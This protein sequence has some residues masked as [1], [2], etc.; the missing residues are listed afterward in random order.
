MT[1]TSGQ[2]P[3]TGQ[4]APPD[5]PVPEPSRWVRLATAN[6][7]WIFLILVGLVIVFTAFEPNFIKP[8]NIRSIFADQ[9]YL[10]V[11][12]IGET[13]V[14]VTA[15]IDLSVGGVLIFS[16]VIAGK[17]MLGLY[18]QHSGVIGAANA[19]WTV[20]II[21]I[22]AGIVAGVAWGLINGLLVAWAKV[23]PL[24]VTLG[25]LGM[26]TGASYLLTGGTDL[27][28]IPTR[29]TNLIGFGTIGGQLP[30][31]VVIAGV[32]AVLCGLLLAYTRFGRYTYAVGSN[33]EAARR[34]GINV[35]RHLIGVYALMGLLAG[36]AGG[37]NLAHYTT[38]TI[39][40]HTADNLGAI[41]AA[42]I[43]GT[44]LFGGR[45]T[46]AGTVIGVLIPATLASGFVT[47]GVNPYWQYVAVGIVLIGA[48]YLD[49]IRR[50]TRERG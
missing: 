4:G 11:L 41:S 6:T 23:P 1:A 40:G 30:Y 45:G 49:Q 38:T 8:F 12:A 19:P 33:A 25:T 5:I 10:I 15:G 29:F 24:I 46:V 28:G 7:A 36:V 9:S 44:S 39:A 48:V 3:T 31:Q 42:V 50:R 16:G 2:A 21:G 17:V 27:R 13:F 34:V 26:T 32:V 47:I 20:I 37:M 14:I 35:D 43:G 18:G 22:L